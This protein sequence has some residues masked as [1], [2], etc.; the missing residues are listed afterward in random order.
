MMSDNMGYDP[1]QRSLDRL[2][3]PSEEHRDSTWSPAAYLGAGSSDF[4]DSLPAGTNLPSEDQRR[5]RLSSSETECV[6][7]RAHT[8]DYTPLNH[9]PF[10]H[11]SS[12]SRISCTDSSMYPMPVD[13]QAR[14]PSTE[15]E[16][17]ADMIASTL[18]EYNPTPP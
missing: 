13:Y 1:L 14:V 17:S 10:Y 8:R 3:Q 11:H 5:F 15:V 4:R 9:P 2:D 12:R 16:E 6:Q 18:V 7:G